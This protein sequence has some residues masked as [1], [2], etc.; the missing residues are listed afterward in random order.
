MNPPL[1]IGV[2]G[3]ATP[4]RHNQQP[5]VNTDRLKLTADNLPHGG[6]WRPHMG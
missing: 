4:G 3:Q 2:P 1:H 5:I 6:P